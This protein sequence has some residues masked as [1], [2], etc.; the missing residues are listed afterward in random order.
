MYFKKSEIRVYCWIPIRARSSSRPLQHWEMSLG[1]NCHGDS[2]SRQSWGRF[3]WGPSLVWGLSHISII[4]QK[5]INQ[6]IHQSIYESVIITCLSIYSFFV[7]W[8]LYRY[9]LM[10]VKSLNLNVSLRSKCLKYLP[11]RLFV[12][13]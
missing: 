12:K 13:E 5:S 3:D 4:Q 10:R 1:N 7:F 2:G 6:S 9:V 8:Q 11:Y